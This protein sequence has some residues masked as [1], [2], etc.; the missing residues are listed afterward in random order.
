MALKTQEKSIKLNLGCGLN[1]H[2]DWINIDASFTARISKISF[3][4]KIVCKLTKMK[5]IPWPRNI[6]IHDVRKGLPFPDNSVDAI[7]S[8]HMIEHL[9]YEEAKFVIQECYRCLCRGGIIRIIVP[10]LYQIAK[11]YVE[12]MKSKP[13]NIHSHKFLQNL[14]M[15]EHSNKGI[16]KY[17]RIFDYS[18]HLYMYDQYSLK[19]LLK[20]VGFCKIKNMNYGQSQIPNII[21]VERKSRYKMS[22]CLEGIKK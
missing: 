7:F 5:P 21:Q 8:S 10:D 16:K 20:S 18:R 3:L 17:N 9:H 12:L 13:N 2:P 22:I 15:I 19:N 4:Y 6:K 14:N 11:E 1:T